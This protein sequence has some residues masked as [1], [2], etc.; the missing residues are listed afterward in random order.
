MSILLKIQEKDNKGFIFTLFFIALIAGSVL[1]SLISYANNIET[2]R[3][4]TKGLSSHRIGSEFPYEQP[5]MLSAEE[6]LLSELLK[7][8]HHKVSKQVVAYGFLYHFTIISDFGDFVVNGE[9][10]SRIRAKEILATAALK[11]TKKQR[12]L[13]RRLSRRNAARTKV[14]GT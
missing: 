10:L 9:D 6:I 11:E 2:P 8:K 12:H 3:T 14:Y 7:S 4:T 5:D 13:A 1:F